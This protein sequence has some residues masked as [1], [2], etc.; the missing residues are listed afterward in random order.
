MGN[1]TYYVEYK[2]YSADAIKGVDVLAANKW[3]AY[4][5]ATY[6]AI[7]GKEGATPFAAWVRSVTYNNGNHREFNTF[8]GNPI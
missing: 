1:K 4:M 5:K 8:E 2:M 3:D 6:E 7:P